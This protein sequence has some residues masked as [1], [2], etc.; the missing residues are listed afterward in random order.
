MRWWAQA[1]SEL[2]SV[3]R[4]RS[5]LDD[6]PSEVSRR[7]GA[8]SHW[9]MQAGDKRWD[10]FA[11]EWNAGEGSAPDTDRAR[12]GSDDPDLGAPSSLL[13]RLRAGCGM[14]AKAD[15]LA[16]L[17]GMEEQPATTK[18]ATEAT[19]YSRATIS[20]ALDDLSRAGFIQK[21]RGRPAEYRAPYPVWMSLLHGPESVVPCQS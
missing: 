6:F 14:S 5:L 1:D 13:L 19:G 8:Y 7:L 4:T 15:V 20:G 2:L 17:L 12:K 11:D 21:T 3:Q 18:K 16:F 10:T 9:A